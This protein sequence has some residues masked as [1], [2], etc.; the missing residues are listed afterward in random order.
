ML[1]PTPWISTHIS[2]VDLINPTLPQIVF[3]SAAYQP[4]GVSLSEDGNTLHNAVAA[5]D[6]SEGKSP[7]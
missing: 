5:F 1:S 6:S 4:H 3:F 7:A 2:A